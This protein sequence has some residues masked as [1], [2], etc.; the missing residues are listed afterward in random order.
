MSFEKRNLRKRSTGCGVLVGEKTARAQKASRGR[1]GGLTFAG[2]P[3]VSVSPYLYVS[4]VSLVSYVE[5]FVPK[6]NDFR[7]RRANASCVL[8]W[9]VHYCKLYKQYKTVVTFSASH[10]I[11]VGQLG[12]CRRVSRRGVPAELLFSNTSKI[13]ARGAIHHKE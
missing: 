6:K 2:G 5:S 9:A 4:L 7:Y 11:V 10:I 3:T 8:G 12:S 13:A 1:H